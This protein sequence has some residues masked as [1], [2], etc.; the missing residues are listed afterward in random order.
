[1]TA[2]NFSPYIYQGGPGTLAYSF[3]E[4][5]I[6]HFSYNQLQLSNSN[7]YQLSLKLM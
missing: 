7:N 3:K 6:C 5:A 1:M 4:M 2:S